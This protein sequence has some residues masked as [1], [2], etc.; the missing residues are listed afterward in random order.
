M[1]RQPKTAVF[2]RGIQANGP[3]FPVRRPDKGKRTPWLFRDRDRPSIFSLLKDY[4]Y[5]CEKYIINLNTYQMKINRLACLF[6]LSMLLPAAGNAQQRQEM[7]LE[8]GWKFTREDNKGFSRSQ[9]D[10]KKW[11]NVTV[12]HDWAIY[13]PFSIE[14]DKQHTA[15]AQDGQTAAMEHAGRT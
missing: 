15:I 14:N 8:K 10:D 5:I 2:S 7:L 3:V 1:F 13:G 12:P 9:W 6:M 11:Q 4:P